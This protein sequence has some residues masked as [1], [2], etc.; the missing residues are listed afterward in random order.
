M[1]ICIVDHFE[2]VNI[3][4]QSRRPGAQLHTIEP[5]QST[6]IDESGEVIGFSIHLCDVGTLSR[7]DTQ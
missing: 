6:T 5:R 3:E 2:L 4:V 7:I 1:A